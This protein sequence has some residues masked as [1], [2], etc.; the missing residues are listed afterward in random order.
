[1]KQKRKDLLNNLSSSFYDLIYNKVVMSDST[2]T[3]P[4]LNEMLR[5]LDKQIE[6]DFE[7]KVPNSPLIFKK[8]GYRFWDKKRVKEK[9]E[10]E[11]IIEVSDRL[12]KA[13][14]LVL[15]RGYD[16][17]KLYNWIE[18]TLYLVYRL[19]KQENNY[20]GLKGEELISKE[21]RKPNKIKYFEE[22]I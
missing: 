16:K 10:R 17:I 19:K 12:N 8:T 11:H 15:F 6:K 9:V 21:L 14:Q 4:E 20:Q 1:M 22:V 13:K 3:D 18:K 5:M 2:I 7:L